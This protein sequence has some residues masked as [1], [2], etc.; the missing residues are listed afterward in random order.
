GHCQS[1]VAPEGLGGEHVELVVGFGDG[2]AHAGLGVE[3][4]VDVA[5]VADA[6]VDGEVAVGRAD[7]AA[8]GDQVDVP[9][10]DVRYVDDT[11]V[12]VRRGVAVAVEDRPAARRQRHV[13]FAGNDAVDPQVAG[14]LF[15]IDALLRRGG[16]H[17]V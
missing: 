5:A 10:H 8:A 2:D 9:G 7:A 4:A 14:R 15:D 3:P 17:A 12:A 11:A 13:A 6:R 1:H 16:Q